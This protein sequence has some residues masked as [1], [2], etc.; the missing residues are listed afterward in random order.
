MTKRVTIVSDTHVPGSGADAPAE[1]LFSGSTLDLDDN[2]AGQLVA[3]GR[4]KYDKDAKLRNTA[5]DRLA[6][7]DDRAQASAMSPQEVL[8][9]ALVQA[10][11]AH[12]KTVAPAASAG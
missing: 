11:A 9:A 7:I 5:K 3:A 8:A 4:A 1:T 6:E 10:L 2:V 12:A